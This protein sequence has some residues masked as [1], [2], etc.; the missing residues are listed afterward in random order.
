MATIQY[1]T[2]RYPE[3]LDK[4]TEVIQNLPFF[5]VCRYHHQKGIIF[6]IPHGIKVDDVCHFFIEHE[7]NLTNTVKTGTLTM[8]VQVTVVPVH[9]GVFTGFEDLEGTYKTSWCDEE[10]FG[11]ETFIPDYQNA[12]K[13][14]VPLPIGGK[15]N[16]YEYLNQILFSQ[17]NDMDLVSKYA[18]DLGCKKDELKDK[19]VFKPAPEFS[20]NTSPMRS[21]IAFQKTQM[22]FDFLA[23]QNLTLLPEST[24]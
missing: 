6:R 7:I 20:S 17:C 1:I 21:E 12:K 23:N 19:V 22:M 9:M 8:K 5:K 13:A 15:T 11:Y 24:D 18:V 4:Y 10:C 3:I 2:L 14:I 16:L